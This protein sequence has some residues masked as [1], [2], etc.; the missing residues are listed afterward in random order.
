MRSALGGPQP[1]SFPHQAFLPIRKRRR[2]RK[3][4]VK[5]KGSLWLRAGAHVSS[6]SLAPVTGGPST[7]YRGIWRIPGVH[8]RNYISAGED[9]PPLMAGDRECRDCFGRNLA[10]E[11]HDDS[12]AMTSSSKSQEGEDE[13]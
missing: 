13:G 7:G 8:Y 4:K 3:T 10:V 2:R 5:G 6:R 1:F 11:G 12:L 9:R